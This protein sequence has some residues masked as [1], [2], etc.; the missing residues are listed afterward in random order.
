MYQKLGEFIWSTRKKSVSEVRKI[1]LIKWRKDFFLP[2]DLFFLVL[3][4]KLRLNFDT[5][6]K[7]IYIIS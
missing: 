1:N 7:N 6:S 4:I 2:T 5:F 3:S